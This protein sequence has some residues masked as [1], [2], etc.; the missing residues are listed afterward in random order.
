MKLIALLALPLALAATTAHAH[1]QAIPTPEEFTAMLRS[2]EAD[3]PRWRATVDGVNFNN[4]RLESDDR[5]TIGHMRKLAD[6]DLQIIA[7]FVG[8]M[9]RSGYTLRR[10]IALLMAMEE[11]DHHSL[12][13]ALALGGGV[14]D[15]TDVHSVAQ[16]RVAWAVKLSDVSHSLDSLRDETYLD[17]GARAAAADAKGAK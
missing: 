13:L 4:L 8:E 10:E 16:A 2:V 15:R 1:A 9:N 3:V 7:R 17:L 14:A 11:L 6:H 5:D 12:E